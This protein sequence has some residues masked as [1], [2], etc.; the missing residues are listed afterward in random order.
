MANYYGCTRTNYFAVTDPD[1]LKDIVD[2][3]V[4][5]EG[6]LGFLAEHDGRWAFGAYAC[7]C[8]LHPDK[9]GKIR[10]PKMAAMTNGIPVRS[11]RP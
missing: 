5:N 10:K 7:I 1:K 3:I 4:W 6:R 9:A 11:M 8:G 2:R